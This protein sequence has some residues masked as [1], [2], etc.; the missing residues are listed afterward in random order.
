[1]KHYDIEQLAKEREELLKR[2]DREDCGCLYD[3]EPWA[4]LTTGQLRQIAEWLDA[5]KIKQ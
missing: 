5:L 2:F 3:H 4:G 1:M